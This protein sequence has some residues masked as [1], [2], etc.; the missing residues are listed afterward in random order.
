MVKI[1]FTCL[2]FAT[3]LF[4]SDIPKVDIVLDKEITITPK[5]MDSKLKSFYTKTT[6]QPHKFAIAKYETSIKEYKEY[7]LKTNQ[8][9]KL[10]AIELAYDDDPITQVSFEDASGF[11]KY[12]KGD[13]PTND[14]WMI[15]SSIKLS[16]SNCYEYLP[17]Y[18]ILDFAIGTFP[19]KIDSTLD[20]CQ[21]EIDEEFAFDEQISS[22]LSV[23]YSI[24]NINGTFGMFGNVWE[25][26][27]SDH[28]N[29]KI[30]KGGSYANSTKPQFFNNHL[31]N[32]IDPKSTRTNVGFRCVWKKN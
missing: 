26:T 20:I 27:K 14:E 4:A 11:C 25:W 18:A 31:I 10:K 17:K 2:L 16:K 6:I 29:Y 9:K 22:L 24:E 1:Q 13:L 7:L 21:R 8:L 3:T 30:I 23:K 5:Q 15:A 32:F 12:H 28:K 19:I